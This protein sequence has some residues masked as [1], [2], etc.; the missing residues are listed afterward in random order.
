MWQDWINTLLGIWLIIAGFIPSITTNRGASF[1]N[2]IIVGIIVLILA[3]W[4]AKS[5]WPEWINAILGIWLI[6]SAFIP[7]LVGS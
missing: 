1:W 2:Y 5:R 7:S 6:I 4:V 3:V